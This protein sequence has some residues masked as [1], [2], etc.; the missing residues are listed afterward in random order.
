MSTG[1]CPECG[2]EVP[3]C[4]ICGEY[5]KFLTSHDYKGKKIVLCHHHEDSLQK[6]IKPELT[7]LIERMIDE[8]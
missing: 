2:H 1:K 5:S 6:L 3:V 4:Y 8:I 7:K